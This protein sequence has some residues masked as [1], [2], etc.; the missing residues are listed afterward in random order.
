[1][2]RITNEVEK[3][4]ELYRYYINEG[5]SMACP[6]VTGI[7]ATWLEY[8]PTLSPDDIK[9]IFEETAQKPEAYGTGIAEQWG[10]NGVIDAY[11]GLVY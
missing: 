9:K 1:M 4:G 2:R 8:D 3:D 10:P 6:V 5:T 11:A 7:I